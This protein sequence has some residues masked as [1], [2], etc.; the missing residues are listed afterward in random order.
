MPAAM[1]RTVTVVLAAI[2]FSGGAFAVDGGRPH[3]TQA[4]GS[5]S[6]SRKAFTPRLASDRLEIESRPAARRPTAIPMPIRPRPIKPTVFRRRGRPT[7]PRYPR[8]SHRPH[9]GGARRQERHDPPRC[10]AY[11]RG[12]DGRQMRWRIAP[13]ANPACGAAPSCPAALAGRPR[14]A[15]RL[16]FA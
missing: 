5:V 14:Y 15:M 8:A 6:Q 16:P 12:R 10:P 4:Q 7:D 13:S 3:T 2:C 9:E 1:L 11:D